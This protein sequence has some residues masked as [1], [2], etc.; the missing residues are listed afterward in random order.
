MDINPILYVTYPLAG[1]LILFIAIK[2]GQVL[3]RKYK[4]AWVVFAIGAVTFI[5]SQLVHI[6]LLGWLTRMFQEG[7]LPT[8]P[9][10]WHLVFNAVVLGLAAGLSE[11]TMRYLVYRYWIKDV[12]NWSQALVFGAGHGGIEAIWV[13]FIVILGYFNM[14]VH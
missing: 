6:P 3:I 7:R 11:E 12:R 2:P 14:L 10:E 8:P 1:L 5:M 4:V 13:G 9:E